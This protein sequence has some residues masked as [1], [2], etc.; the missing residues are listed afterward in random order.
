M[1]ITIRILLI[2]NFFYRRP[3]FH[4]LIAEPLSSVGSVAD[5]RIG[6][7]WFDLR[8]GKYC[9]RG[10]MIVIVTRFIPLSPLSVASTMIM[11]ESSQWLIKNIVRGTG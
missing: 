9:I 11:W 2:L 3:Y 8:H 1:Y 4:F 5:L 6:G 10:M 7:R